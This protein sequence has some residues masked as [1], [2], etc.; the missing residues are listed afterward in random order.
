MHAIA[1]AALVLL[2]ALGFA[3]APDQQSGAMQKA[4]FAGILDEH[5]AIQYATTP[6]RD[7]VAS[8]NRAL[9]NDAIRF[10]YRERGGYLDAVLSALDVSPESQLLVFSKTG[11]QRASTG[12]QTPRA[13]YF[14]DAVVV[15]YIP[16]A[17]F[18]EIASQ[19]P[20][21]GVIFY[22]IDQRPSSPVE[23]V[24]RTQCLSCHVSGSTMEVPGVIARSMFTNRDGDVMPQLGS[25]IVDHRTPLSERWGGF[26]VTGNYVAP[27]YGGFGHMGNV[28]TAVHPTSGPVT[29]SNEVLI[30]WQN[31]SAVTRGYSSNESDIAAL[32]IFDHQMRAMNLL[33]RLNWETRVA[34]GEGRA[35]FS[36]GPLRALL[37]D[38]VDYF[39][40]TDE[41]VPPARL[42]PRPGFA[43]SFL[44]AGPKDRRGRS[45]RELDL[46]RR[47]FRVPLSYMIYTAAFD[48]LPSTAKDAV[49]RRLHKVLSSDA[50]DSRRPHLSEAD[51]Q[52]IIEILR[53]TK[54]D[55]PDWF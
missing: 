23:I 15:G 34:M 22:T 35:D 2:G 42:T 40:F 41:V 36:A 3:A 32:M 6:T 53:E 26:F 30:E 20:S 5:P 7:P 19:D 46:E 13:L 21:Q 37:D 52:G 54:N 9:A 16:G 31:S 51:R 28:T 10:D 4:P 27:V 47:L 25:S 50:T 33:T 17:R 24:R 55:L 1:W 14:N 43:R 8:L 39:L 38:V 18:I 12:P 11:I 29:T 48:G 45:L 44:A 49:Y